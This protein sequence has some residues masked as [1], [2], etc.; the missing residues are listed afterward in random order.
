MGVNIVSTVQRGN[1]SP[2]RFHR[3][4]PSLSLPVAKDPFHTWSPH[5]TLLRASV[6][7]SPQLSS[8]AADLKEGRTPSYCP[9]LSFLPLDGRG[10]FFF[11]FRGGGRV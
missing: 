5:V 7:G 6:L 4:V 3:C 11:L 2:Q 8:Y 10:I 1:R 9:P